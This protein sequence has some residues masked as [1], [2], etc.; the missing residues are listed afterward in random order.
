MEIR[1][2]HEHELDLHIQLSEFAFQMELTDEQRQRAKQ[3]IKPEWAYG[4]FFEDKLASKMVILP[5]EVY[6]NGQIYAMGGIS[7]VAT[8]PEYRRQGLVA[9]LLK[10]GLEVMKDSG[11]TISFL[12]PFAYPFYRKY[13]WEMHGEYK[14]WTLKTEQLPKLQG[15]GYMERL[16]EDK[17]MIYPIYE[18][19]AQQYNGTMKRSEAW[20]EQRI[21]GGSKKG[22]VAVYRNAS[23]EARGY[24]F[25]QVKEEKMQI[26]ELVYLDF[27]CY[28]G[29]W[30]FI[31]QH[32]S[33]IKEVSLDTPVDESLP[34]LVDNPRAEQKIVPY[35]MTR[36]VDV[37][38]F[39]EKFTLHWQDEQE[40]AFLHVY[41]EHAPWNDGTFHILA[42]RSGEG[43]QVTFY[44]RKDKGSC[45]NQPKKGVSCDIQT[46]STMLLGYQRPSA[47]AHIERIQGERAE[48]LQWERLVPQRQVFLLDFF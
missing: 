39:L 48:I 1:Q 23:G 18:A 15:N 21:F 19:Y 8:W 41:D 27:D 30:E 3:R 46:L 36:I 33:M 14:Q 35:F 2:L 12:A 20:W 37:Q 31:K 24:I 11:Q 13:G 7:S 43:N 42:G 17:S 47:L 6:L 9:K 25:Y 29:L 22:L 45:M 38:A 28:K 26:H 34:L 10:H 16:G 5:L 4:A 32:D 40:Q 44:P